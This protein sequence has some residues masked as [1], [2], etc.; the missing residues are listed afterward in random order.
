M[1]ITS[2]GAREKARSLLRLDDLY[3]H[4][5]QRVWYQGGEVGHDIF[6]LWAAAGEACDGGRAGEDERG[7]LLAQRSTLVRCEVA[8]TGYL[9]VTRR[10]FGH[11]RDLN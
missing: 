8:T 3:L 4:F 1:K 2:I 7:D 6:D 11:T 10:P 9:K 5:D